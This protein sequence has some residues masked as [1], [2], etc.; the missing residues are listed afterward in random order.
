MPWPGLI[1]TLTNTDPAY[2][3]LWRRGRRS[4]HLDLRLQGLGKRPREAAGPT[5][6]GVWFDEEPDQDSRRGST[7]GTAEW[8]SSQK[9]LFV[10]TQL[11]SGS[12]GGFLT[13]IKT[14]YERQHDWI[15]CLD[16]DAIPLEDALE[17]IINSPYF[18]SPNIGFLCGRVVDSERK[19][20]MTP[21]PIDPFPRW[22]DTIGE[23][24]CTRVGEACFPGLM[25][26]R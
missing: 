16:D 26:S 25:V 19:T 12:S 4:R 13:A 3:A 17:K 10:V 5:I 22:Y 15:Y 20:Y 6:D 8:L 11:D 18:F 23:C 21:M 9:D 7:D 24:M 1:P 2:S 14:G